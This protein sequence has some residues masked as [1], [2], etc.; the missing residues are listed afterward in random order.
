MGIN[1]TSPES[2]LGVR[3]ADT[4]AVK[5]T[6]SGTASTG[7]ALFQMYRGTSATATGSDFGYNL[8]FSGESFIIREL[9]AGGAATQ[10]TMAK[11]TGNLR[12]HSDVLRIDTAK[13]PASAGAAGNQ[14]DICWDADFVY[15]CVGSSQWKRAAL[16]TW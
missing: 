1:T 2:L 13:T 10:L 12:L 4:T 9:T 15:V 5:Y 3:S 8:D 11:T 16:S 7:R 6:T 14:G